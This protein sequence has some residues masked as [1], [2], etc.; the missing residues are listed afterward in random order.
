MDMRVVFLEKVSL[1]RLLGMVL[2]VYSCFSCTRVVRVYLIALKANM[3]E[4]KK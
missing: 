2:R 4:I 1:E 3:F